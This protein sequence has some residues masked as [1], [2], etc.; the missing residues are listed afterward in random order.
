MSRR[1]QIKNIADHH[2]S[3]QG[4]QDDLSWSSEKLEPVLRFII[5]KWL[6][7]V[8]IRYTDGCLIQF[9]SVLKSS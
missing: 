3:L 6:A 4:K 7:D 9:L 1:W 2:R 5:T 8:Q